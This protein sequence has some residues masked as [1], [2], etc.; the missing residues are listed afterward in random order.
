MN[1]RVNTVVE[2][3]MDVAAASD[4]VAVTTTSG[5]S[6]EGA[7]ASTSGEGVVSSARTCPDVRMIKTTVGNSWR[8]R[9]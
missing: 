8:I 4:L 1:S 3:G 7:A 6:S 9:P 2:E 5:D